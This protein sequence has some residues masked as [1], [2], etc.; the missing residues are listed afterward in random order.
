MK[1]LLILT[2]LFNYAFSSVGFS[3]EITGT[4]SC[5]VTKLYVLETTDGIAKEY[6]GQTEDVK[7]GD[8]REVTYSY[9]HQDGGPKSF[10]NIMSGRLLLSFAMTLKKEG[11]A[12]S[13]MLK[14]DKR[15]Y[16]GIRGESSTGDYGVVTENVINMEGSMGSLKMFRY[17][18]NDWQ[19]VFT[20][21]GTDIGRRVL[22]VRVYGL[23]C[24]H[25]VDNLDKIFSDAEGKGY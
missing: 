20:G 8:E 5:R 13:D 11:Y 10:F 21:D 17:F 9:Y 14:L 23:D 16:V 12:F 18:K 6:F 7:V 25:T 4:F 19:G 24:R 3:N 15:N 2:F 22:G 1:K